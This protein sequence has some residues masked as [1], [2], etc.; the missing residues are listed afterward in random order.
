MSKFFVGQ[1]VRVNCPESEN[2]YHG[3]ETVVLRVGVTIACRYGYWRY[4]GIETDLPN[5]T[6]SGD[7]IPL[8]V[9]EPHHL[10]P[11]LPPPQLA[12]WDSDEMPCDRNGKYRQ[13][14]VV[15]VAA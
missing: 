4:T 10:E 14:E 5:R 7:Y 1:R 13:P 6:D 12:D 2:G 3:R 8:C 15:G 11:L 9:Y